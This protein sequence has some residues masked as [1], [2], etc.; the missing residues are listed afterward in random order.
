[1]ASRISLPIAGAGRCGFDFQIEHGWEVVSLKVRDR[2]SSILHTSSLPWEL[3]LTVP[4]QL[5]MAPSDRVQMCAPTA[6]MGGQDF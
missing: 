3:K 5:L 1:M 2:I 4:C 6:A